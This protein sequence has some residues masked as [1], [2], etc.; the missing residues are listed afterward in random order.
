MNVN[1]ENYVKTGEGYM[2]ET[3]AIPAVGALITKCVGDEE[4][5]LV[6][7]RKKNNCRITNRLH[8]T[9]RDSSGHRTS[10]LEIQ[11]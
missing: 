3:F 1:D 7:N 8:W 4:F 5:I 11:R 6:Q 10:D 9:D 2:K